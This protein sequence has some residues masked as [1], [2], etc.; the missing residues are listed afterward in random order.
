[1]YNDDLSDDMDPDIHLSWQLIIQTVEHRRESFYP[2][3]KWR[4]RIGL[5][6]AADSI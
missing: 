1:M 3:V 2:V 4:R 6:V 5:L